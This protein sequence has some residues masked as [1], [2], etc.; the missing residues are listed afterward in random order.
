MSENHQITAP[1]FTQI[2][3][4]VFDYWMAIL[5]PTE[6]TILSCLCRKTFGWHKTSEVISKNQ[7]VK[8]TR[9]GK[10]SVDNAIDTLEKHG[11][12]IK[13]SRQN[14][15][16]TLPNVY[17]LNIKKPADT[18]YS[19]ENE[20]GGYMQNEQ[21]GVQNM[22]GGGCKI[23]TPIKE[24]DLNKRISPNGERASEQIPMPPPSPKRKSV[25]INRQEHVLTTQEEHAD[26]ISRFGDEKT[27]ECYKILS[28][29]KDDVA[30]SRWKKSDYR[31]ILRW[32]ADRY[33]EKHKP[34]K[35]KQENLCYSTQKN[36]Q[37]NTNATSLEKTLPEQPSLGSLMDKLGIK[38]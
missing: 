16:G 34:R 20:G 4:V 18:Q 10:R 26:L 32:V 3:N 12:V 29:W 36:F 22:H 33:D 19:D 23:C 14:E 11:L 9:I 5:S 27:K 31:S 28:E 15:Y 21:G 37:S 25:S 8:L 1:N 13:T 7:I 2:P 35:P 38:Y 17:S 24:R 6:F 30:K